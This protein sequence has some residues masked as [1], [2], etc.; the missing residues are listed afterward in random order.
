M[1]PSTFTASVAS[2]SGEILVEKT[3]SI[4][5]EEP[6]E[7][8][9]GHGPATNRQR[10][11][12]A[13]TMRTP[14]HDAE[15]AVGYLVGEGLLADP[16]DILAVVPAESNAIRI[17]L[18][19]GVAVNLDRSNR[20]GAINSSCGVCGKTALDAIEADGVVPLSDGPVVSANAIHGLTE[21]LR[22]AQP[23][24]DVTGG[25][26][27]VGLF[28]ASGGLLSLREDV[29]RHNALDKVV[30]SE[31]LAGRFPLRDRI[32][33]ASSRAS[34]ELVQKA[35]VAGV[36]VFAA[37]GAPSSLAVLLAERFGMTLLGFVRDGRFN[38][39]AGRE[40]IAITTGPAGPGA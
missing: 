17:D 1:S 24:F 10:T 11:A 40:R 15:L 2:I 4:A 18:K 22:A 35:A 23:A 13:V 26:H 29:G 38:V 21:K 34:F 31:F 6:L 33:F 37:V 12:V 7:I 3:D 25:L 28:D 8:R 32:L 14:G 39:Y 20:R 30:G 9:L 5:I 27:A 16:A 36:P 19:P